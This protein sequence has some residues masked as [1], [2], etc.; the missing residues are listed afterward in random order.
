MFIVYSVVDGRQ[1][2]SQ[3][4]QM[5]SLLVSFRVVVMKLGKMEFL[6]LLAL[7]HHELGDLVSRFFFVKVERDPTETHP[8][9]LSLRARV[10]YVSFLLELLHPF[11]PNLYVFRSKGNLQVHIIWIRWRKICFHGIFQGTASLGDGART[12]H[13][14]SIRAS[15]H[16]SGFHLVSRLVL[17]QRSVVQRRVVQDRSTLF[18][19]FMRSLSCLSRDGKKRTFGK[20]RSKK[21]ISSRRYR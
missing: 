14:L 9:F 7:I 5:P 16:Q 8:I 1:H 21:G 11:Q 3:R 6:I 12:F 20:Q 13:L 2:R 19:L 18:E 17:S 4:V 10:P 15:Q